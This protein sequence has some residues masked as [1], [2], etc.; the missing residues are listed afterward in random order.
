M[1][2][3]ELRKLIR[4]FS[5]I[6]LA[7]ALLFALLIHPYAGAA[8]FVV[9]GFGFLFLV[10]WMSR[11]PRLRSDPPPEGGPSERELAEAWAL[12]G[13][14][15]LSGLTGQALTT[16]AVAPLVVAGIAS[17]FAFD[18]GLELVAAIVLSGGLFWQL[19]A[20]MLYRRYNRRW[21]GKLT[22][23]ELMPH[24]RLSRGETWLAFSLLPLHF[25]A[26]AICGPVAFAFDRNVQAVL[27]AVLYVVS[28]TLATRA[29]IR[30]RHRRPG[31][32]RAS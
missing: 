31:R 8:A 9:F 22:A 6:A 12:N 20:V 19:H 13:M 27:I 24:R 21:D 7:T 5:G 23:D 18:A 16:N 28:A 3:A 10:R 14:M 32:V 30:R 11:Q 26:S 25:L 4:A 29:A 15:E 1:T 2:S 17:M